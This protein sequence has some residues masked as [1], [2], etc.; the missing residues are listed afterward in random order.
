MSLT[1]EAVNNGVL[2][3][4]KA[5]TLDKRG[6]KDEAV[7]C[8]KIATEFFLK[9]IETLPSGD[10]QEELRGKCAEYLD[11]VEKIRL[12]VKKRKGMSEEDSVG[13]ASDDIVTEKPNVKWED[14]AGL[15][16][17]KKSLKEAC[18]LPIKQPQLFRGGRKPW[19]C[20]LLFGPPGT[21][22]TFLGKAIATET[23]STFFS[24]QPATI[25]SKYVGESEKKIKD[26]FDEAKKRKP[27]IIFID[28]IDSLMMQRSEQDGEGSR[29]VKNQL[30]TEIDGVNGGMEGITLLCATNLPEKL[31]DAMMR[32]FDRRIYIPLPDREARKTLFRVHMKGSDH[33]LTDT[34]ISALS[35]RTEG[36]SG[37]DISQLCQ[38][39]NYLPL[40]FAT[41]ATHFK[42]RDGHWYPCDMMDEGAVAKT[43]DQVEKDKLKVPEVNMQDFEDALKRVKPSVNKNSLLKYEKFT[44]AKGMRG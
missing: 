3:A 31:D 21:G 12:E 24:I 9:A 36:F 32:R 43:Y 13:T 18:V 23:D 37:S 17:A 15:E 26:V 1:Q 4:K 41:E 30:L 29:R 6:E 38:D 22:K 8:Y 16:A 42:K 5:V 34:D 44:E 19:K 28:E 27:S 33:V 35:D 10:Q 14:V 39:A 25:M 2:A 40:E 20:I 7:E 11:R